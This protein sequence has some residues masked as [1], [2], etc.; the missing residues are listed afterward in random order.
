M[1]HLRTDLLSATSQQELTARLRDG[2]LVRLASGV[3]ADQLDLSGWPEQVYAVRVRA[4]AQRCVHVVSHV[5]AAVLHGLP[6]PGADLSEVHFSRPGRSGNDLIGDRRVH[7][8]CP[9]TESLTTVDGVLVTSVARTVVDV[10]RTQP[11]LAAVSAADAAL[12]R[13]L[14]DPAELVAAF[15]AEH[16]WVG[17]PWARKALRA[18]DGRAESPGE[19]W[20]RLALD[21]LAP[22]QELQFSVFDERG[23]FVARPDG[24][25][26]ELGLIWEY[27]GQGKY[28]ELRPA[29]LSR[30][31]VMMK[32]LERQ[33][34]LTRLG[35][36]V[37]R[38]GGDDLGHREA[39]RERAASLVT[40]AMTKGW[41]PPR[42]SYELKSR[43]SV[44]VR[45]PIKWADAEREERYERWRARMARTVDRTGV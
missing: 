7:A 18:A 43:I 24:G 20:A 33:R 35:W 4:H 13:G 16:R 40:A 25:F 30:D 1:L 23:R 32:Q 10:A 3:Y 22:V 37:L 45:E 36:A 12:H 15:D 28:E 26:P 29:G 31:D 44:D 9:G 21:G 17:S 19:T 34:K 2:E 41:V 6:V 8:G 27:D 11:H 39:F 38:G 14:A 5:S 42:G